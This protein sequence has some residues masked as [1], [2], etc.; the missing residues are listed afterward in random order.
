MKKSVA[1]AVGTSGLTQMEHMSLTQMKHMSA[2]KKCV[3]TTGE[4]N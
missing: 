4:K 2:K 3:S 1:V